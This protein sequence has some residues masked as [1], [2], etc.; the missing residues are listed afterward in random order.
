MHCKYIQ[1]RI[2]QFNAQT[3][4]GLLDGISAGVYSMPVNEIVQICALTI[5]QGTGFQ[6]AR[7]LNLLINSEGQLKRVADDARTLNRIRGLIGE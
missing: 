2:G 3:L 5:A 6:K 1:E 4:T 7:A